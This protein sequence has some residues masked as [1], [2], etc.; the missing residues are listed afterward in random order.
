MKRLGLGSPALRAWA[1]YDWAN[2]AFMTT[3]VAAVFPIYFAKVAAAGFTPDEAQGRFAAASALALLAVALVAPPL[4]GVA[5]RL[6]IRKRLLFGFAAL[7]SLA[8][9]GLFFVGEG[10]WV[11]AL[12]FFGLGN[13]GAGASAVFYDALLPHLAKPDEVDRA[14]TA[15]FALGYL[16]GGLLLALNLA[17]ITKP[18]WFGLPA[19]GTL[20]P[21][22]AFLSVAVWWLF[23]TLPL[24]RRVPEPPALV[25]SAPTILRGGPF[26]TVRGTLA[27]IR[28]YPEAFKMLVAFLLYNDGIL[29]I[30]RMATIFGAGIG[31]SSSHMIL[32]LLLVQFV[33]IPCS[34]V[35]GALAGRIGTKRAVILA[36]GVYCCVALL[37]YF[38]RTSWHFFALAGLVA[39]VQGGAQALSRSLFASLVP[40]QKSAEFFGFFA[41]GEKFAGV[42]GPTLF[43][44]V[45]LTS[46]SSRSAMLWVLGFFVIG[47][48][49]LLRVNVA[50]GRE[51]ARA[52]EL[53]LAAE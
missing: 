7:G 41:V 52:A 31:L 50:A 12:V 20:G 24:M 51:A 29:T 11:W 32:A 53:R 26:A 9:V 36:L 27:E 44:T 40:R 45:A 33:G 18:T 6:A 4:G 35:F 28:R 8:C 23:F 2:S 15:G 1:L 43:A 16:G 17:W 10:D 38:M 21:R 13:F 49:L 14:S 37:G 48:G 3:V 46:G 5:D 25:A 30:I 47:G 34:F 22:L 39:L 19:E 42:L